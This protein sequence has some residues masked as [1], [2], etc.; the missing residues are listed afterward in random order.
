MEPH[1]ADVSP[2]DAH[3]LG[4]IIVPLPLQ[5]LMIRILLPVQEASDVLRQIPCHDAD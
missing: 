1:Q 2:S 5:L 4:R 3:V